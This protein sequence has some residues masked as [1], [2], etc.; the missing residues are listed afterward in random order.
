MRIL[1]LVNHCNHANGNAHVAIDLACIQAEHGHNVV[2]ASGG[3]DYTGLFK[4]YGVIDERVVQND[5]NP[6]KIL[7]SLIQLYAIC[8][9]FR[10]DVIHAHMMASAVFGYLVSRVCRIPLVTTVHNSFD[11]HSVLMRFGDKVVAVSEAERKF[12]L[13]RGFKASQLAV[14][15]NG[16]NDS[17]REGFLQSKNNVDVS[18]IHS[19]CV[20]TVCGLHR[21]KGVH[22]LLR[23]F[24]DA[25]QVQPQWH[26]YVVGD[27]PDRE[28]LIQLAK[29]LKLADKV[30]F[31]GA[32]GSPRKILENSEIFVLASYADPCSLA[33][34]EARDAGCAI[35]ATAV[36]GTPELL[37]F[38]E[39]GKLVPA[40]AASDITRELIPLMSDAALLHAWRAKSK[41]GSEYFK[42]SRVTADYEA[43]YTSLIGETSAIGKPDLQRAHG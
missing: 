33:V 18:E 34:A 1:H 6:F 17:P 5:K 39:A 27:G 4:K 43:V 38:G 23:G 29:E 42:V 16:P 20:T 36:G 8:R 37:E 25:V 12:L 15:I 7:K 14:V 11:S 32:V 41:F 9:S 19:P 22:D 40:G 10:P 26:L 21:R 30:R 28:E 13:R 35:I 31:L 2:Y 3:G 24:A